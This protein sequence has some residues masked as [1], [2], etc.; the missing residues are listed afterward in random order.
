M[1]PPITVDIMA[2]SFAGKIS[3]ADKNNKEM[4]P[5]TRDLGPPAPFNDK[6]VDDTR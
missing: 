4:R 6:I 5:S 1:A 2:S 3:R